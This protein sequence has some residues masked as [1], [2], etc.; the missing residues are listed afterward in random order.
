MS[1]ILKE[2][3][4]LTGICKFLNSSEQ[5]KKKTD[6]LFTVSDVCQYVRLGHLPKYL[7]KNEIVRSN[8]EIEGVKLYNILN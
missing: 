5:F 3:L 2:G 1:N 6:K 7:G 8:K 4:T